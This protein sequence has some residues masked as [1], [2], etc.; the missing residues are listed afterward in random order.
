MNLVG[1]WT[2]Q[3][4]IVGFYKI[5]RMKEN[6]YLKS[7]EGDEDICDNGRQMD[8]DSTQPRQTKHW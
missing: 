4:H 3:C 8:E 5:D 2:A 6:L 7:I 1:N